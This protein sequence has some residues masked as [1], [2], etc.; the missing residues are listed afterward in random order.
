MAGL[1]ARQ[2]TYDTH[3]SD[4][5]LA[6][7]RVRRLG[8]DDVAGLLVDAIRALLAGKLGCRRP[9]TAYT[10]V[11][12]HSS[13]RV[14]SW[15][16]ARHLKLHGAPLWSGGALSMGCPRPSF[17]KED[18]CQNYRYGSTGAEPNVNDTSA[19]VP[20]VLLHQS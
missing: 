9:S 18:R 10:R 20:A 3:C 12:F 5:T 4:M 1:S 17:A 13:T 15:L 6:L 2:R 16:K 19:P 8:R 7:E 14:D 11:M